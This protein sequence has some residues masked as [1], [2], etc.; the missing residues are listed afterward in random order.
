MDNI[1]PRAVITG[2]CGDI[3][4]ALVNSF[5]AKGYLVIATDVL[6]PVE[7][8]P[9]EHFIQADLQEA[10]SNEKCAEE[11]FRQI[12]SF[13]PEKKLNALV[14]NAAVQILS[15]SEQL[16]RANWHTTLDVN[17][18]APF[19]L[20][21]ALMPELEADRGAIVNVSSI[22]ATL[23]K[24]DFVAYATSKAALSAMTRCMALDLD[25]NV[26]INA[27]EPAAVSTKMLTAGFAKSHMNL[28]DLERLHP[29]GRVASPTEIA[30][31]AIF[32]CSTDASFVHGSCLSV[33]GGIH[34]CLLDPVF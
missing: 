3:G 12:K 24:A 19:F 34:S 9:Y 6:P 16:T 15:P 32:L 28:K 10:V 21:Q 33:S 8:L 23:T 26:R 29:L 18:L 14:N 25:N 27:I 11:F 22:H 2:A 17:L 1:K 7:N 13:L 5:H 4:R 20:S 30:N 31:A